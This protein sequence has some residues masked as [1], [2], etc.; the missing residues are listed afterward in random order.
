MCLFLVVLAAVIHYN[1]L[2][3][4][5]FPTYSTIIRKTNAI[6]FFLFNPEEESSGNLYY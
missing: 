6:E 1:P 3:V 5:T 4:G 2:K